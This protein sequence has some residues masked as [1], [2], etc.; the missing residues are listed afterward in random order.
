MTEKNPPENAVEGHPAR[1]RPHRAPAAEERQRDPERSRRRLLAAA[2]D[3]FAAKGFTGARV[4]EIAARAGVNKQLIDYYFGG[5]GG[6]YQAVERLWLEREA[7]FA[8]PDLPLDD[9]VS[10]YL[11]ATLA[12]PRLSR[13]LVWDG[14]AEA[15]RAEYRPPEEPPGSEDVADLRR[16]QEQGELAADLDPGFVLLVF[17]GAIIAPTVMPQVV[18]RTTGIEADSPQFA[19]R[20]SEQLKRIVR[21]LAAR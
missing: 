19:G 16:R 9:L 8:H 20:Y 18:R 17:M 2:L 12:D 6:L 3:E 11:H 15:T 10:E 5:K 4:Q 7:E 1:S 21:H 14:L 13:L